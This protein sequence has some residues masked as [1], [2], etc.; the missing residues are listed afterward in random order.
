MTL[1]F[2]HLRSRRRSDTCIDPSFGIFATPRLAEKMQQTESW[3]GKKCDLSIVAVA[4]PTLFG[5][6]QQRHQKIDGHKFEGN[7]GTKATISANHPNAA[8]WEVPI[9]E[10]MLAIRDLKVGLDSAETTA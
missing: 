2:A 7:Q 8:N 5:F 4:F 6:L 10:A 3:L 9:A 1:M